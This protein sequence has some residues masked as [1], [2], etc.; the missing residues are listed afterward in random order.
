MATPK[1]RKLSTDY[2]RLPKV[3]MAIIIKHKR[4]ENY[5]VFN[6]HTGEYTL[7]FR[8]DALPKATA[9]INADLIVN[10]RE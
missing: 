10:L 9:K 3:L 2:T 4:R 6:T 7:H 8:S 5:V 1:I